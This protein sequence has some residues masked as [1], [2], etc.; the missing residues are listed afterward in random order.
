VVTPSGA[1]RRRDAA[2][3]PPT[4]RGFSTNEGVPP[5][6]DRD[7]RRSAEHPLRRRDGDRQA[8]NG[9][10]DRLLPSIACVAGIGLGAPPRSLPRI[11]RGQQAISR[12]VGQKAPELRA[13]AWHRAVEAIA[14]ERGEPERS[15]AWSR[16]NA[17]A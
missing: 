6:A 11:A 2:R 5:A 12:M 1:A 3:W 15:T 16:A 7:R 14:I 17:P 8:A 13:H 4:A 9:F 10:I